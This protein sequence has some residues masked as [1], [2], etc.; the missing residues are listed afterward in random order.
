MMGSEIKIN[1]SLLPQSFFC[2]YIYSKN[3]KIKQHS[4]LMVRMDFA[5][6]VAQATSYT[7]VDEILCPNVMGP[8][9]AGCLG[10]PH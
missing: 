7:S 4:D 10:R 9:L 5:P 1:K 6:V 8:E 3:T 2:H